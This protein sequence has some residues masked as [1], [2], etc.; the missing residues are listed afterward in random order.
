VEPDDFI[1]RRFRVAREERRLSQREMA[2][3]LGVSQATISGI[4][5]GRVKIGAGSLARFAEIL[6]KPI[7]FFY[8]PGSEAQSD[9][10]KKLL[11]LFRSLS[12][13]WQQEAI[14]E[15]E[16]LCRLYEKTK[17]YE[18]AQVPKEFYAILLWEERQKMEA[19]EIV[20]S[21]QMPTDEDLEEAKNLYRRFVEWRKTASLLTE[22]SNGKQPAD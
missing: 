19:E 4:E 9:R 18:R 2:A 14:R 20:T 22:E 8:P 3:L 11:T 6:G 16:K 13:S 12:E 15:V 17:V 10:E 1:R 5:T 7:T 21:G